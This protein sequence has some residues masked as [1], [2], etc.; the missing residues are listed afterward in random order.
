MNRTQKGNTESTYEWNTK[1][2]SVPI[3]LTATQMLRIGHQALTLQVGARYWADT[4]DTSGP[5]GW[6]LRFAVNFLFP[7]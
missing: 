5:K 4:P 6:G 1:Q 7:K 2:W 3:N